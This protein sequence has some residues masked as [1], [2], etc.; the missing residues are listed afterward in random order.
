[1]LNKEEVIHLLNRV[2]TQLEQRGIAPASNIEKLRVLAHQLEQE[3]SAKA[4]V[5]AQ[6]AK[7]D[8]IKN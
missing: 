4:I 5:D 8:L 6:S 1:M 3:W 7:I 2:A